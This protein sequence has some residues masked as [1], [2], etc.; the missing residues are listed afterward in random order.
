MKTPVSRPRGFTLLET[1]IAIGV[2][3]VLLTGFMYV[4]GPAASG[5]R[6][7]INFQEADRLASS[8]E[9]ELVTI[10]GTQNDQITGFEKAYE[11]IEN[12]HN[13]N[14]AIFVYQYRGNPSDLR[15]DGTMNAMQ[16]AVGSPGKDYVVMP[17]ARRMN[18]PIFQED[19]KAIEGPIFFVKCLQ[20]TY[21]AT[22]DEMEANES[23]KGRIQDPAGEGGGG[24]ADEYP[25]AAIAFAAEFHSLPTKTAEYLNGSG[26]KTRFELATNPVF[27]R[28][29][30]VRR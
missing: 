7:A 12:S 22:G 29:L 2:L 13:P 25:Q 11:W 23:S 19:L 20:L 16:K 10:R 1:V 30:A 9:K 27:V 3:A 14:Q 8:L 4:F 6:R 5:I 21:N 24:G 17:M 28:N 15:S 18:D 26:F